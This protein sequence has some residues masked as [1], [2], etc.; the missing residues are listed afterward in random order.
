M[1]TGDRIRKIRM[2]MGLTQAELSLK[3]GLGVNTVCLTENGRSEPEMHTLR[4]IAEALGVP[5]LDLIEDGESSFFVKLDGGAILPR[6]AHAADAGFDLYS[7]VANMIPARGSAII[8]TGVHVAIPNGYAGLI[9][10]KSGL[11]VNHG[12]VSD[13]LIDSGYTGSILV[14]LYNLTDTSYL[15]TAGDKIS[16]IVFI[17]IAQPELC[18]VDTLN[19]TER[20][21][22]GFGSTGR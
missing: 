22:G 4:C 5:V 1:T 13:G 16:Q 2:S 10:S 9:V 20:G 21:A 18:V 8:D 15:I 17:P 7:P 19:D 11:N 14:K 3:A 12:I 6:R